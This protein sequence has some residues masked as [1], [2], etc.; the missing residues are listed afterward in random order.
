MRSITVS[1][2][3]VLAAAANA[4]IAFNNFGP[5]DTYNVAQGWRLEGDGSVFEDFVQ[6]DQFTSAATGA[7]T[8]ISLAAGLTVGP[9]VLT[10][11][12]YAD[13]GMD[14]VGTQL[15]QWTLN[16]A[17]GNQFEPNPPVVF[18]ITGG[19]RLVAGQKYWLVAN[20]PA[21][22]ASVWNWNS[23]GDTGN[24]YVFNGG[25][26]AVTT[27]TRGAFRVEVVPEPATILALGAGLLALARRRRK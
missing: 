22:G 2:L 25:V 1:A 8:R 13:N 19:P 7:V 20:A 3:L 12:L 26:G 4:E 15:G 11:T 24:H 5:G 14:F 27:E 23:I 6:G 17:L 21:L 18:D 10:I 9:N 16:D